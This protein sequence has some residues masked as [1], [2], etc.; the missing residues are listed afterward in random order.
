MGPDQVRRGCLLWSLVALWCAVSAVAAGA[1]LEVRWSTL[2]GGG[3][4]ATAG[5]YTVIGTVGQTDAGAPMLGGSYSVRGGFWTT[6]ASASVFS[7]GFESGDLAAWVP[8]ALK[9]GP[10]L[11]MNPY[12]AAPAGPTT[13]R[14]RR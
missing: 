10:E 8:E 2:D 1:D 4:L 14:R 5:Q 9:S 12:G 6:A 11:R 3:G 7:D 13:K